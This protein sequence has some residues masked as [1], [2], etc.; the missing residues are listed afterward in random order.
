MWRFN[1]ILD[2]P[3]HVDP[4]EYKPEVAA[5]IGDQATLRCAVSGNPNPQIRWSKD[6]IEVITKKNKNIKI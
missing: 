2:Q 3:P 6:S 1:I 5:S 4:I